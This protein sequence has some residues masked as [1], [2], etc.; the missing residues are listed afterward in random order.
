MLCLYSFA[1]FWVDLSCALLV[2]RCLS[3]GT[4]FALCLLLYNFCAFALQ[5]PLGLLADR[6]DRNGAVAAAGCGLTALAYLVPVPILAA[7]TAGTGNALFHLGGGI[8]ALNQSRTRAWALGVFVSPGAL[9]LYL[10]TLWGRGEMAGLWAGPALLLVLGGAILWLC[11][12]TF[13]SLRSG[14]APVDLT[15]PQ[16]YGVLLPLLLVVVLRSYM[17]MNQTFAWKGT[18][19]WALVLTLALVLGKTAGGFAMD[20]LGDRRASAWSLGLA[21]ALY[22]ASSLPLPGAA[23]VFL[24]NMTMP[25]TLWAAARALPGAKGF[26]FGLLTFG[27]FLGFLPSWLGWTSLLTGPL[28]YAVMA[29]VSLLL[30]WFSLGKEAA[31]C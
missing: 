22:L 9:G 4:D 13:G 20:R 1:H 8:D 10:G 29:A 31:K 12:R 5:M 21:A 30:L 25:V 14:N 3:R 18:G 2:F 28:S 26:T 23:A 17:G 15:A 24:F 27:L 16:G 7:V 11:R 6:L 19:Q